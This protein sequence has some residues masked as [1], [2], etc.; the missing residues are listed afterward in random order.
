MKFIEAKTWK[1]RGLQVQNVKDKCNAI[2]SALNL[3]D[4]D[5]RTQGMIHVRQCCNTLAAIPIK[6][7]Q[8]AKISQNVP[9]IMEILG[10]SDASSLELVLKDLNANAKVSFLTVVQFA[11]ENSAKQV[12]ETLSGQ[13][14]PIRFKKIVENLIDLTGI[15][16][17]QNKQNKLDLLLVL[18]YLRN[19]LHANGVQRKPDVTIMVDGEAFVFEQDKRIDCTSWSHILFALYHSLSVYEE[20]YLS[21]TVKAVTFIGTI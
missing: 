9:L 15:S 21:P 13:D 1:E 14:A 11:L 12:V 18:A 7:Q 19:T 8:N 6:L 3:P 16:S 17:P 2:I 5:I 20:M 4:D 10:L